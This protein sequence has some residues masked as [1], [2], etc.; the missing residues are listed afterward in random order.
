MAKITYMEDNGSSKTIEV[1]TGWSL[2]QGAV[3]NGV[4]GIVG[5]CGGS[6]A[7]ATSH[8]YVDPA[9]FSELPKADPSE[10]DMLD[11]AAAEVKPNSRLS[12][13]ILSAPKLDG[14]ILRLPVTQN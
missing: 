2:M 14:L 5:E 11:L 1:P 8:C 12:C 13:Q 4:K 3:A 10:I 9:R 7:C 6:M